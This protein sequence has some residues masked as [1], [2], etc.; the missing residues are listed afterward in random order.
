MI[1]K[2]LFIFILSESL[3]YSRLTPIHT[4]YLALKLSHNW[5]GLRA[6]SKGL[7]CGYC[8]VN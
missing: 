6:M 8:G 5:L 1:G 2:W 4:D 7:L 3:E